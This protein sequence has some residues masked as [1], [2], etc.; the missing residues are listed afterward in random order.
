MGWNTWNKRDSER[1][2]CWLCQHFQRYDEGE[3]PVLCEGE[4]RKEGPRLSEQY[5][6]GQPGIEY[7]KHAYFGFVPY[8]N[9]QWCSGFQ[10]SL[11]ANIPP[12]PGNVKPALADCENLTPTTWITPPDFRQPGWTLPFNKKPM[13]ASC[14]F[15]QHFSREVE[16]LDGQ[17]PISVKCSGICDL[18]PPRT[19][20]W[21]NFPY[22]APDNEESFPNMPFIQA[23]PA[24]WCSRWE[25]SRIAVA[26]VPLGWQN[27]PCE[28]QPA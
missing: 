9:I 14:W 22:T 23:A 16:D 27:L 2:S 6:K 7:A 8:G 12:A 21:A 13:N 17:D 1:V 5:I 18:Q 4:C 26:D 19:W 20:T 28:A 11:E 24:M 3:D 10:R 15:C 25:R